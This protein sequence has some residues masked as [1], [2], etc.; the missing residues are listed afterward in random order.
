MDWRCER[1]YF[2]YASEKDM[3]LR[4]SYQEDENV[5]EIRI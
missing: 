3:D 2:I 1:W 4:R 5:T